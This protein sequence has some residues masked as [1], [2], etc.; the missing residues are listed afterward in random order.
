MK[1]ILFAAV[2]LLAGSQ[3]S[4]AQ[5]DVA[6]FLKF[7]KDDANKLI[8]AYIDP[9]AKTLGIGLNNSWY[10]S[11]ETHKLWGFDLAFS[12][13]AIQVSGSDKTFDVNALG[14]SNAKPRGTNSMAPTA[15]GDEDGI[16]LDIYADLEDPSTYV[17]SLSTPGGSG[18]D[19]V[20][21]PMVQATF[22]LLPHTDLIG[23]WVPNV[24]FDIEDD[25]AEVGLWGLGVK[26]NFKESLP[27]IKHLPFDASFFLGYSKI[28]GQIGVDYGLDNYPGSFEYK[29]EEVRVREYLSNYEQD[30]NQR[31]ETETSTFKYGLIVS[32]KLSVITFYVSAS[33]NQSKTNFDLLGRYPVVSEQT[34]IDVVNHVPED[35]VEIDVQDPIQLEIKNK[36]F[37]VDAGFRLKLAFFSLYGSVAK[38][39]YVSY[40]AGLSFGFR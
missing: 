10:N 4:F 32:K 2:L 18:V 11:A 19:L 34:I 12:V 21:I 9:Y 20:P 23:R 14:L 33:G 39:D 1:K 17:G 16:V 38:A 24:K 3:F 27:F 25:Q 30:P 26:H 8:G 13:S 5:S 28:H 35:E 29:K 7:G 36:Y 37:A 6:D 40:N 15:A 31:G 22:G